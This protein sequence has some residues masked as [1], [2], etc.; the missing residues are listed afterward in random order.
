MRVS[1][2]FWG[3]DIIHRQSFAEALATG[4]NTAATP[5]DVTA[6]SQ[7]GSFER[8]DATEEEIRSLPHVVDEIPLAVWIAELVG[9]AERFTYYGLTTPWRELEVHGYA[10]KIC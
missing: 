10:G 7:P 6:T 2:T 4:P 9:A 3:R 5:L 1:L 8:R